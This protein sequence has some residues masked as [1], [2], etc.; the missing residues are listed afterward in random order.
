ME[1]LKNRGIIDIRILDKGVVG[2]EKV[3]FHNEKFKKTFTLEDLETYN[4]EF[5]IFDF[6]TGKYLIKQERFAMIS[7]SLSKPQLKKVRLETIADIPITTEELSE[8]RNFKF[9][10]IWSE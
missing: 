4:M 3:V 10:N 7:A 6:S 5:N 8:M 9:N 2:K 1:I